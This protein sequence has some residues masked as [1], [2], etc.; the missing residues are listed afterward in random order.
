MTLFQKY[1][2]QWIEIENR[3]IAYLEH[4]Q[5]HDRC[6][7]MHSPRDLNNPATIGRLFDFLGLQRKH[8]EILTGGRRNASHGYSNV[9]QPADEQEAEEVLSAMPDRYLEIFRRKPYTHFDWSSRLQGCP[10]RKTALENA[11]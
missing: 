1:L 4:H 6:F 8:S 5:L 7:T 10:P 2:I 11:I 3:A 9:L